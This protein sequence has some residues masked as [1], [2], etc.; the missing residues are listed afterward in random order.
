[1]TQAFGLKGGFG[2][3]LMTMACSPGGGS[4][5]V[6]TVLLDGD[7]DLSITM[8]FLSTLASLGK[9]NTAR[10]VIKAL[11]HFWKFPF[12]FLK[13]LM[14]KDP[15]SGIFNTTCIHVVVDF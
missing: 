4:S 10:H 7:L 8:T 6:W 9:L 3:G 2:L 5:N 1:M 12:R 15:S 13:N 14:N 11:C